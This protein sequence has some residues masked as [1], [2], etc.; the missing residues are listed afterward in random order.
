MFQRF[1][2]IALGFG[3]EGGSRFIQDQNRRIFEDRPSDGKLELTKYEAYPR[4]MQL[5]SCA[6]IFAILRG[7]ESA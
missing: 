5:I 7:Y 4:H 1:L 3:I 6:D 2:N